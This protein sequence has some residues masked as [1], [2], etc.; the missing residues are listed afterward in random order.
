M[1][2]MLDLEVGMGEQRRDPGAFI[3]DAVQ[4][5]VERAV[6]FELRGF[7]VASPPRALEA[8]SVA[9]TPETGVVDARDVEAAEPEL[10]LGVVV[11]KLVVEWQ[12]LPIPLARFSFAPSE[13]SSNVNA[14]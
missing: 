8:G 10:G 6:C 4:L 9:L 3:G 5:F 7:D 1:P 13:S 2:P 12:V 11:G 14:L